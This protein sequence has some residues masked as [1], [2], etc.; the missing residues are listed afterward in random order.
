MGSVI[1]ASF[2]LFRYRIPLTRPLHVG[3]ETLHERVGI[4][5]RLN[6]EQGL[7]GYG[8]IGPLPGLHKECLNDAISQMARLWPEMKRVSVE[9]LS[10]LQI[11]FSSFREAP[12]DTVRFGL[13]M[14]FLSVLAKESGCVPAR[15]LNPKPN[16]TVPINGL[17]SGG[18]ED[19]IRAVASKRFRAYPALKIKVGYRPMSE[20]VE[21][22]R[23]LRKGYGPKVKLRLDANRAY[24]LNQAIYL[25]GRVMELDIEYIEEPLK[26]PSELP[27]F[28]HRTGM[29]VALDESLL[30]DELKDLWMHEG[31][32]AHVI[33]PSVFG[34]II[35][36]LNHAEAIHA[37]GVNPV[38]SSCFETGVAC[39]GL[40][41]LAASLSNPNVAHGLATDRWLSMDIVDP[42]FNS[43][44][45]YLPVETSRF[46]TLRKECLE[47]IFS[48]H[49]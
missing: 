6:S 32:T 29:A 48:L 30:E 34:G 2:D 31:V 12:F 49:P 26:D 43:D 21:T 38:I 41:Q 15:Y 45:G 13:E 3:T 42:P 33:K 44:G 40:V 27:E 17:F 16:E 10:D 23:L 4:V 36:T 19:A 1:P 46:N 5:L 47:P 22:V 24:H 28:F 37:R 9:R 11:C 14:A 7:S 39:Y 35:R 20:T 25:A 18:H 8:E